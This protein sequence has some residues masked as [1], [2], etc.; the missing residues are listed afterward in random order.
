MSEKRREDREKEVEKRA[1]DS[2]VSQPESESP[3]DSAESS[4]PPPPPYTSGEL[5]ELLELPDSRLEPRPGRFRLPEGDDPLFSRLKEN[6]DYDSAG[7][8]RLLLWAEELREIADFRQLLSLKFG[9]FER[10]SPR[11]GRT[12]RKI[13]RDFLGRALVSDEPGMG[14]EWHLLAAWTEYLLRQ[15]VSRAV[16][17][18]PSSAIPFFRSILENILGRNIQTLIRGWPSPPLTAPELLVSSELLKEIPEEV[19]LELKN[20]YQLVG[21]AGAEPI[22]KRR[23]APWRNLFNL[24]PQYLLISEGLPILEKASELHSLLALLSLPELPPA[25]AFRRELGERDRQI[26]VET[27][28]FLRP[29]LEMCAVRHSR[30]YQEPPNPPLHWEIQNQPG[31]HSYYQLQ[32]EVVSEVRE[33]YSSEELAH[34]KVRGEVSS[35]LEALICG[36]ASLESQLREMELELSGE[37]VSQWVESSGKLRFSDPRL[38]SLKKLVN[39]NPKKEVVIFCRHRATGEFLERFVEKSLAKEADRISVLWD[40]EPRLL[41]KGPEVIVFFDLPWDFVAWDWRA[42]WMLEAGEGNRKVYLLPLQHTIT[43]ELL[44]EFFKK[45][46]PRK[47]LPGE[48]QAV[49]EF[50]PE[51]FRYPEIYIGLLERESLE[52]EETFSEAIKRYRIARDLNQRLFLDDYSL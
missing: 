8:Y 49:A 33:R 31:F 14:G 16:L 51:E 3:G 10:Y 47:L 32:K 43:S 18:A 44:S 46:K 37:K 42:R 6:R 9:P 1:E 11:T 30:E 40:G 20:N 24:E 22:R 34:S 35:L 23:S 27:R 29:Y 26:G 36:P 21:I 13:L 52:L 48:L 2:A 50:L 45:V 28:Q 17:F 25:A 4:A 15:T 5:K 41:S 19:L 12:V 39:N 38:K 7:H